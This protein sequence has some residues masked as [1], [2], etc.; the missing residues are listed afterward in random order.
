MYV[1][2]LHYFRSAIKLCLALAFSE[3]IVWAK[4]EE[5]GWAC[6][7]FICCSTVLNIIKYTKKIK[8]TSVNISKHFPFV[9]NT[10]KI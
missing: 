1:V 10:K 7:D 2:K 3:T 8:A 9:N 5:I 6:L 4:T